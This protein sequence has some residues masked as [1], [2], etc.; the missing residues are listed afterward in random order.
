MREYQSR[1]RDNHLISTNWARLSVGGA[2]VCHHHVASSGINSF[3]EHRFLVRVLWPLCGG[4]RQRYFIAETTRKSSRGKRKSL[5]TTHVRSEILPQLTHLHDQPG[6]AMA[7][8]HKQRE[9]TDSR[10]PAVSDAPKGVLSPEP[11]LN[12]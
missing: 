3:P 2:G 8:Q 7:W 11:H 6:R 4:R 12:N 1:Q 5:L 9:A 10:F